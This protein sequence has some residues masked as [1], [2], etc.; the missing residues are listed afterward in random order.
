MSEDKP[1]SF[2]GSDQS[3]NQQKIKLPP[4]ASLT[5]NMNISIPQ[6]NSSSMD[7]RNN[8]Y[9]QL[10][11]ISS[12]THQQQ[13]PDSGSHD[14][15]QMRWPYSSISNHGPYSLNRLSMPNHSPGVDHRAFPSSLQTHHVPLSTTLSQHSPS[16]LR[17]PEL[18]SAS[19]QSEPSLKYPRPISHLLNNEPPT[20]TAAYA[21]NQ[22]Q[23]SAPQVSQSVQAYTNDQRTPFYKANSN[24]AKTPETT[25]VNQRENTRHNII[26]LRNQQ[27]HPNFTSTIDETSIDATMFSNT[28]GMPEGHINQVDTKKRQSEEL[29]QHTSMNKDDQQSNKKRKNNANG[30]DRPNDDFYLST[31]TNSFTSASNDQ[32]FSA[33][34]SSLRTASTEE[35]DNLVT[36]KKTNGTTGPPKTTRFYRTFTNDSPRQGVEQKG[37]TRTA[38]AIAHH[39][40]P[41]SYPQNRHKVNPQ[42]DFLHYKLRWMKDTVLWNKE[43]ECPSNLDS[44]PIVKPT[45]EEFADPIAYIESLRELGE[46][47]GAVKIIANQFKYKFAANLES[48]WFKTRRQTWNSHVNELNARYIFHM[49]LKES[50]KENN[51]SL[52]KLPCIDKRSI[53]LYRLQK[54]VHLRGGYVKCCS[55]KMWAQVGRELGFYGKITSSLS[56][57]I[58]SAYQRYV[59]PLDLKNEKV[60]G[61][62]NENYISGD[63]NTHGYMPRI[64]GSSTEFKRTREMMIELGFEPFFDKVTIQKKGITV[65]DDQTLPTYDFYN[66]TTEEGTEDS[67]PFEN[68]VSSLYNIK[69]FNDKSK[70]FRSQVLERLGIF[71]DSE[72]SPKISDQELE[73]KFWEILN[74]PNSIMETEIAIKVSTKIHESGLDT[75]PSYSSKQEFLSP[76]N[77]HNL[78]VCDNSLLQY[79]SDESDAIIQ[80]S[81][82]FGMFFSSQSWN[83]EEHQL[84]AADFQLL[85][86]RKLWYFIPPRFQEKYEA[87]LEDF[88]KRKDEQDSE[89]EGHLAKF[90]EMCS[91]NDVYTITTDNGAFGEPFSRRCDIKNPRFADFVSAEKPVHMN[92]EMFISPSYLRSQGIEVYGVYQEPGEFVIKFPRSYSSSISLGTTV[93][94][95][96]NF[97]TPSWL[98]EA[99]KLNAWLSKQTIMPKFSTLKLLVNIALN[100]DDVNA[101]KELDPVLKQMVEEELQLRESVRSCPSVSVINNPTAEQK[102]SV[103]DADVTDA[104]PSY[105]CL[106]EKDN[107]D[108]KFTMSLKYFLANFKPEIHDFKVELVNVVSDE[109]LKNTRKTLDLKLMTGAMWLEKYEKLIAGYDKPSTKLVKPLLA[110]GELIFARKSETFTDEQDIKAFGCFQS[111]KANVKL[112]DDWGDRA[113]KFLQFKV[114]TR[115]RQRKVSETDVNGNEKENLNELE[116]LD[117]LLKEIPQLPISIPEMDQLIEFASEISRFNDLVEAMFHNTSNNTTEDDDDTELTNLHLLGQSFG[118]KLESALL[119]D[120]IIKRRNWL[121]WVRSVEPFGKLED[122]KAVIDEG[123]KVA[124]SLDK[125][126]LNDLKAI[127]QKGT[128]GDLQLSNFLNNSTIFDVSELNNL[129]EKYRNVPSDNYNKLLSLFSEYRDTSSKIQSLFSIVEQ[130]ITVKSDED[131]EVLRFVD[132][133]YQYCKVSKDFHLTDLPKLAEK[134]SQFSD[135]VSKVDEIKRI[136]SSVDE[137]TEKFYLEFPELL[138][139]ASNISGHL[140]KWKKVNQRIL[141]EEISSDNYCV[142]RLTHEKG[143]MIECESCEQWFHFSC[144]G[145]NEKDKSDTNIDGFLCPA[146]DVISQFKTT[147]HHNNFLQKKKSLSD[148]FKFLKVSAERLPIFPGIFHQ[149]IQVFEGL[150]KSRLELRKQLNYDSDHKLVEDDLV[151]LRFWFRKLGACDI[152]FEK[153]IAEI[154]NRLFFLKKEHEESHTKD[155]AEKD[156]KYEEEVMERTILTDA[157]TETQSLDVMTEPKTNI[158]FNAN[159]KATVDVADANVVETIAVKDIEPAADVNVGVAVTDDEV[160]DA[161]AYENAIVTTNDD[162]SVFESSA[163]DKPVVCTKIEPVSQ[164]QENIVLGK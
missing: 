25:T 87:I 107:L 108:S 98:K 152:N 51:V 159:D 4:L 53:D 129:H 97:A 26:N 62:T 37:H 86:K 158:V 52:T 130:K 113:S 138:Q 7:I 47:Y 13:Y 150:Y 109:F 74:N 117:S 116:E 39:Y 89:L 12:F 103:T 36:Q 31:E 140:K 72:E 68:R 20:S 90:K 136:Q 134:A 133:S 82:T 147:I 156:I 27:N 95:T 127:Y 64:I 46:K 41:F 102:L 66:W 157:G 118:V 2:S 92:E 81:M 143:I 63:S 126:L 145:L 75:K 59:L 115:K 125:Q 80:P 132:T 135:L 5:G 14:G 154:K 99:P 151:K 34:D 28:K 163:E 29:D 161:V 38:Q 30:V 6:H 19:F 45:N 49:K 33:N 120:R 50:C 137:W 141:N 55:E 23:L 24:A 10:P 60:D 8:H 70:S 148:F 119:L 88:I 142:C 131:D 104:Y 69:Q 106:T 35:S 48:L 54:S 65:N 162:D 71:E 100:C 57:S 1:N 105:V 84:Y 67:S 16:L 18:Y 94:E 112:T 44:I 43:Q 58:K 146:C 79:L 153:D 101:L 9:Q 122:F 83:M 128:E 124:S 40:N 123:E 93:N 114:S 139:F 111:L 85:G 155:I 110:E 17:P 32:T 42:P 91:N 78:S 61:F 160:V 149:L 22:T 56:S 21:G 73:T 144:L 77:L 96:V 121:K 3:L 76:W 15:T 11:S 164:L